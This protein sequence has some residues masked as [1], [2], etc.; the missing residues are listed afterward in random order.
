M[1]WFTRKQKEAE[2]ASPTA[3][4]SQTLPATKT[5]QQVVEEIHMS[6]NT[7]A[8]N[9]LQEAQELIS[10]AGKE[11]P[12]LDEMRMCGFTHVPVIQ[13]EANKKAKINIATKEAE[14]IT[15]FKHTYPVYKFIFER[16][17]KEICEKYGLVMAISSRYKGDIPYKNMQEIAAFNKNNPIK[18]EDCSYK[19]NIGAGS[20]RTISYSEY[21]RIQERKS[22]MCHSSVGYS[23]PIKE[24]SYYICAPAKDIEMSGATMQGYKVMDIPDPVVLYPVRDNMYCI[25]SAWGSEAS[26]SIV[27]NEKMN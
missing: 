15:Y 11:D 26:D 3:I 8:E 18:P 23:R 5:V 13:K 25:V 9:A 20:I 21:T 24:T 6:F 22:S 12:I 10:K 14:I 27:V 16:Q 1:N 19:E 7:A 17:V 4:K 2:T